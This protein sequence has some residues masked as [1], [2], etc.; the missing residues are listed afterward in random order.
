MCKILTSFECIIIFLLIITEVQVSIRSV[1][2]CGS[3]VHYFVHGAI[4][5]FVVT[6]P[7][8]LGHETAG[9]VSKIGENVKN[10][11][12]GKLISELVI[13]IDFIKTSC[14]LRLTM[15]IAFFFYNR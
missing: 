14:W 11:K 12:V 13:N 9:V 10:L 2:I 3:D 5:Q 1:G 15:K 6:K 7:M 8:I 4:G